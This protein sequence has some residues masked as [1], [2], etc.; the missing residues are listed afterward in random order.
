MDKE[1]TSAAESEFRQRV[2]SVTTWMGRDEGMLTF[3]ELVELLNRFD[4]VC[5]AGP[6]VRMSEG[7]IQ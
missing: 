3:E 2:G 6:A 5:A 1:G 4:A 7:K